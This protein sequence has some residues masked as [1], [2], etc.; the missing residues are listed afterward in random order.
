MLMPEDGWMHPQE[1]KLP[2]QPW[3]LQLPPPGSDSSVSPQTGWGGW[4]PGPAPELGRAAFFPGSPHLG[5]DLQVLPPLF[6]HG[7]ACAQVW[8]HPKMFCSVPVPH[9]TLGTT[10]LGETGSCSP[11]VSI[12]PSG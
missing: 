10:S 2:A 11:L 9:D 4:V 5:R 12:T 6:I 1:W 8:G 7:S 3:A